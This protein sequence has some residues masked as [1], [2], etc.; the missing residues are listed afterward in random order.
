MGYKHQN[1]RLDRQIGRD[2]F[3]QYVLENSLREWKSDTPYRSVDSGKGPNPH[4][5]PGLR[6]SGE[7]RS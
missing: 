4:V 7:K 2:L 1:E 5:V 3:V 6:L